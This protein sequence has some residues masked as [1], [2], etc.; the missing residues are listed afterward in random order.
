VARTD[1]TPR[2][3]E[4]AVALLSSLHQGHTTK[5]RVSSLLMLALGVDENGLSPLQRELLML[6]HRGGPLRH[7]HLALEL[8]LESD[9]VRTELEGPLLRGRFIMMRGAARARE[10]TDVGR[11]AIAP[12]LDESD[13]D[14]EANPATD[15]EEE[16]EAPANRVEDRA[17]N[18]DD[19]GVHENAG[20]D[21]G[22][23]GAGTGPT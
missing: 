20:S 5:E 12:Y 18:T 13:L 22:G 3:I 15:R 2:G 14:S 4:N 11:T 8:G 21:G 7:E 16:D 1:R 9:H 10:L 19:G 6:L 23:D 17:A